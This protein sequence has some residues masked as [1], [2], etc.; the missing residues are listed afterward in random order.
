MKGAGE[1]GGVGG[2]GGQGGGEW[3]GGGGT[4]GA[5][6]GLHG[7]TERKPRS[8]TRWQFG[9]S[10]LCCLF[11]VCRVC[12]SVVCVNA[13]VFRCCYFRSGG[14]GGGGGAGEEGGLLLQFRRKPLTNARNDIKMEYEY[15]SV[16][17][18]KGYQ[19]S[20]P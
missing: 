16:G 14:G 5:G 18:E 8:E 17:P 4:G 10:R 19:V 12:V 6:E 11:S 9:A 15:F 1:S 13:E 20:L 2:G 3:R 7:S